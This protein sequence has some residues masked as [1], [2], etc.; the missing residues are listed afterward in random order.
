VEGSEEAVV[1]EV[2]VCEGEACEEEI[3]C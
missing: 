2:V 3:F 1:D